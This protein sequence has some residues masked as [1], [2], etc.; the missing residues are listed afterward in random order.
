ML[1]GNNERKSVTKPFDYIKSILNTKEYINDIS[2]FIPFITNKLFSGD[3]DF[4]HIANIANGIGISRLPKI[5]IYD[6]YFYTIPKTKKWIKYPKNISEIKNT[7]YI[8]NY[9]GVREEVAKDYMKLLSKEEIKEI[10]NIF[11]KKGVDNGS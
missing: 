7:K 2:G 10:V 5:A 4:V 8:M 11:E 9:F 1:N 3:R 6:L